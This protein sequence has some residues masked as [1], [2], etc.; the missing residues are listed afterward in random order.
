VFKN[1]VNS[2]LIR[3]INPQQKYFT[4]SSKTKR[5]LPYDP[6]KQ[7]LPYDPTKK[8][9]FGKKKFG[10]NKSANIQEKRIKRK[11]LPIIFI[12][13]TLNNTIL[14]LTDKKGNPLAS[15]SAGRHGFKNARKKNSFAAQISST[16]LAKICIDKR[17]RMLEVRMKGLG[18]GKR[19]ALTALKK[20]G[21]KIKRL[22]E[23]TPVPFNGCRPPKKRRV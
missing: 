9:K 2:R 1:E 16:H 8:S 4:D 20:A 21:L 13:S 18:K 22:V 7:K 10:K 3:M 23:L 11:A 15:S 14:T 5:K 6:S 17:I 12:Q 19:S